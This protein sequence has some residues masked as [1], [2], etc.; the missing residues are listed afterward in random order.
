MGA[1]G[2]GPG[3]IWASPEFVGA[4][5]PNSGRVEAGRYELGRTKPI[6]GRAGK[7]PGTWGLCG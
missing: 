2:A 3:C 6:L 4:V 7:E 1:W 5:G